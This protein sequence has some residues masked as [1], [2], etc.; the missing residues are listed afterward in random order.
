MVAF[1]KLSLALL[2]LLLLSAVT[3]TADNTEEYES[4]DP[5]EIVND[6]QD[7][8]AQEDPVGSKKNVYSRVEKKNVAQGVRVNPDVLDDPAGE[9]EREDS[10]KVNSVNTQS[11][12]V[13]DR[14]QFFESFVSSLSM[15]LV[16]ELGDKTFFI[17]ALMA[18]KYPRL[19]IY[20]GAMGALALMTVLSAAL[21]WAAPLFLPKYYTTLVASVLFFVFGIKLVKDAHEMDPNEGPND[22]LR[23]VEIELNRQQEKLLIKDKAGAHDPESGAAGA[24]TQAEKEA[25]QSNFLKL[26]FF[27]AFSLTFFA[28]WGDRSQIATIALAA[29]Q[30]PYGVTLGGI[31][32]HSICTGLAVLGGRLLASRIS[33]RTVSFCGGFLFLIFGVISFYQLGSD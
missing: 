29:A 26:I 10:A 6:I 2:G 15:I 22:E 11:G 24:D 28:E 30:N 9:Y 17:A 33:E 18:M 13:D 23:E 7:P 32:G 19:I 21:G 12:V 5:A 20:I 4:L 27:Q 16:S 3:A 14:K 8:A 1:K 31:L 25:L